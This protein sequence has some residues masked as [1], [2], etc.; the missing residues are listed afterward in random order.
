L[1]ITLSDNL[2]HTWRPASAIWGR[3]EHP[4]SGEGVDESFLVDPKLSHPFQ[5]GNACREP[6]DELSHIDYKLHGI[7]T[8]V[9]GAL[10]AL[11]STAGNPEEN[12]VKKIESS[13]KLIEKS[14][15]HIRKILGSTDEEERLQ[16][17][18]IERYEGIL[19]G[20]EQAL[21]TIQARKTAQSPSHVY[22]N[23]K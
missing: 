1:K 22:N 13:M 12:A 19:D 15:T 4:A 8:D 16:E 9:A 6:F 10:D 2:A 18:M 11:S 21:T 17:A 20:M 5:Q 14:L 7:V 23:R 3:A